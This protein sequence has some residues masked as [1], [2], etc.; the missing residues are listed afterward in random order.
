MSNV[1][2]SLILSYRLWLDALSQKGLEILVICDVSWVGKL[3]LDKT[4]TDESCTIR[5]KMRNED[6]AIELNVKDQLL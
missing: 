3:F 5:P 1:G 2:Q 6:W 4:Y